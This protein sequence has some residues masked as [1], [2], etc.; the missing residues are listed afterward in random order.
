MRKRW[1]LNPEGVVD[2]LHAKMERERMAKHRRAEA[3]KKLEVDGL[4]GT[5]P[6]KRL[7]RGVLSA[8]GGTA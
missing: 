7:V 2:E 5:L 6:S 8:G 3:T 4:Y 1:R